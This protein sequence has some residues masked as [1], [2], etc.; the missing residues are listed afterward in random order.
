MAGIEDLLGG[1]FANVI[2]LFLSLALAGFMVVF[3]Y[4]WRKGSIPFLNKKKYKVRVLILERRGKYILPADTPVDRARLVSEA[5]TGINS[6]LLY[7][8]K[9][10]FPA[11]DFRHILPNNWLVVY[12]PTRDEYYPCT[13]S[14]SKIMYID[15]DGVEQERPNIDISPVITETMKHAYGNRIEKNFLR[16]YEPSFLDKYLPLILIFGT[17]IGLTI[18]CYA[19]LSQ[20]VPLAEKA[21]QASGQIASQNAVITD[22]IAKI[23]TSQQPNPT[24]IQLTVPPH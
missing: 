21:I 10:S 7:S 13:L 6:Y 2:V 12:C 22:S 20:I 4:F 23:L 24:P 17:A 3:V 15:K 1:Q 18:L 19:V 9:L 5:R 14:N 8:R 16:F 11:Y